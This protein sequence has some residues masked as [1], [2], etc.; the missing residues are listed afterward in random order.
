MTATLAGQRIIVTGA[1]GLVGRSLTAALEKAGATVIRAVR[2]PV[3]D[4]SNELSWNPEAGDI[5]AEKFEGA[6]AVVHLAGENIADRRWTES[7]KQ[8]I[9]N[10]RVIGTRLIAETIARSSRRP[11]TLVCASAI[12]YY[13]DR[14][15]TTLAEAATPAGDFLGRVCQEWE[16]ACQP[17]RDAEGVRVVNARIGVILSTEGGALKKMLLPFKLGLGGKIGNGQQFMSWIALDDVV[18]AIV[19]VLATAD[20]SGPV[21]VVAPRAVTNATYTETLGRVLGRPTIFPMPAFAAR[22]AFGEMADALLLSSTRVVPQA[23]QMAR[24][25]FQ[26]PELEPALRH[27]LGR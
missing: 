1:S 27:L 23:L 21:N 19:H 9:R 16:A 11:R 25:D 15:D 12:G 20:V 3:R 14:G 2:R 24:Y 13:G 4:P 7:F 8:K 18:G 5:D 22:L 10:S 17:A 26:Y 6:D